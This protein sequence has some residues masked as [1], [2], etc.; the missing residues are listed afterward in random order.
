MMSNIVEW[1]YGRLPTNI[2]Y[3]TLNIGEPS[4]RLSIGPDK[5]RYWATTTA[6]G[7]QYLAAISTTSRYQLSA[8]FKSKT[9]A[10]MDEPIPVSCLLRFVSGNSV[11]RHDCRSGG[12]SSRKLRTLW[13]HH[14]LLNI[15]PEC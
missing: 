7:S 6:P 8:Y 11:D 10:G 2:F 15:K 13:L 3:I 12:H 4:V 5:A 9:A 1:V 14:E